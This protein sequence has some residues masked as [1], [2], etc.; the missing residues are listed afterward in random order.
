LVGRINKNS[1]ARGNMIKS[2][3]IPTKVGYCDRQEFQEGSGK[4]Y[5]YYSSESVGKKNDDYH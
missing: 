1:L 2:L 5:T 3:T 4:D